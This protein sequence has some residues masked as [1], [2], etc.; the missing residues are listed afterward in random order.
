MR[1]PRFPLEWPAGWARKHAFERTRA[2]FGRVER[3]H[4]PDGT[5]GWAQRKQLSIAEG[6]GR[7]IAELERMGVGEDEIVVSSN[8]K[9]RLDG[10]PRS[11]QSEPDDPGVAVYWLEPNGR[12][13]EPRCI[14]VDRYDR[15]A[16]NL[17]AVAATLEAMRAIERHGGAEILT[18]AFVGFAALPSPGG[19]PWWEILGVPRDATRGVVHAAYLRLRARHHPDKGGSADEFNA[20]QQ[21]WDAYEL[22]LGGA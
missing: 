19:T 8:L 7:V 16:D 6:T 3:A 20:T 5:A 13:R 14:A 4:R 12:Q 21:A 1:I 17:A 22:E 11:G 10:L 18:R 15:V 9:T 2:Q